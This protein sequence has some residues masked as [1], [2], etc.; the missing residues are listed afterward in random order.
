MRRA[1]CTLSGTLST[2]VAPIDTARRTVSAG[3]IVE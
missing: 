3:Y 2:A 1:A